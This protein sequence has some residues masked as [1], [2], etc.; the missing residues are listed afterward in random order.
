M[1][2]TIREF[3]IV[4]LLGFFIGV[5]ISPYFRDSYRERYEKEIVRLQSWNNELLKVLIQSEKGVSKR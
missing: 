3:I 1:K 2:L 5:T 4:L